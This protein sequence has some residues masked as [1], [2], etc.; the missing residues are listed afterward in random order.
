MASRPRTGLIYT[1]YNSYN[2]FFFWRL[3]DAA[4]KGWINSR[5]WDKHEWMG[6][7]H[8]LSPSGPALYKKSVSNPDCFIQVNYVCIHRMISPPVPASFILQ[9]D[10]NYSSWF[11]DTTAAQSF[12]LLLLTSI[13]QSVF[14]LQSHSYILHISSLWNFPGL[15]LQSFT[16]S[17]TLLFSQPPSV[18]SKPTKGFLPGSHLRLSSSR[19]FRKPSRR[20]L[21]GRKKRRRRSQTACY[22]RRLSLILIT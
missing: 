13:T 11:T 5:E 1:D 8:G 9:Q 19:S 10:C 16:S 22:L 14:T 17:S 6:K 21:L 7:L 3:T 15:L 18:C 4:N 2:L 12:T 20:N